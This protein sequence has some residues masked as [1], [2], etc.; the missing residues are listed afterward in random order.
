M[1]TAFGTFSALFAV[2][3][4]G[5]VISQFFWAWL[6][7]RWGKLNALIA[8]LLAYAAVL[9]VTYT[10][11]PSDGVSVMALLFFAAGIANGAY[12]QIPWAMYPDHMDVT[13]AQS[14]AALE[15]GFAAVWMFGQKVANA[16]GPLVMGFILAAAG[17]RESR[18]GPVE[19]SPE[20]LE[21]L[22]RAMTLW[23]VGIFLLSALLLVVIYRPLARDVHVRG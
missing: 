21:A 17:W 1:I 23:P 11:L 12:Q 22:R 2:F 8:G 20:A 3:V 5:A 18:G 4:I 19:Q 16:V 14:G 10:Q 9:A 7:R 13:R 15:G 6:S